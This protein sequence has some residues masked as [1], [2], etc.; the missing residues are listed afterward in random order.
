MEAA[1]A[2]D[3]NNNLT[4]KIFEEYLHKD[5]DKPTVN[6]RMRTVGPSRQGPSR[7]IKVHNGAHRA[8]WAKSSINHNLRSINIDVY[9]NFKQNNLR[10]S[11]YKK[12]KKLA[13]EGIKKYWSNT[14]TIAG[15]RF[16][17][18]VNAL[19]RSSADAIPV[20]L[21]IEESSNYSRSMNPSI[22]G[23]DASFKYQKGFAIN[24]IPEKMI[25]EEFKLVAAHEFGHSVLMYV[26]GINFS[27]GHKGST[28]SLMQSVKS[29]T[30]G[31]PHKGKIDL[32]KYYNESKNN[33]DLKKR[34]SDSRAIE[35]DIKR[36][37]WSSEIVWKK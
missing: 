24:G 6:F 2:K 25:D 32:M 26:G 30:P 17:V 9:L 22:L 11:D 21:E 35:V 13:A 28:H 27:W 5:I 8:T 12:L 37:I 3:K 10:D 1:V 33:A 23:I 34:I 14:V 18:V 36:L 31:F 15:V 20:D 19:H 4:L 16:R 29:S 7:K